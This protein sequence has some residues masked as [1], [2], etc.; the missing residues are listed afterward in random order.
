MIGMRILAVL[1]AAFLV[2]AFTVATVLPPD[3]PLGEALS[4]L[5]L[6]FPGNLQKAAQAHLPGWAWTDLG[7][8]LLVRPAWLLP[9]AFGLICLGAALTLGSSSGAPRSTRKRS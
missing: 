6:G 4:M 8:P 5:D 1:A 2:G 7:Q 9:T 3:L